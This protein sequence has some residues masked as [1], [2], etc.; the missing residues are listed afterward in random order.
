MI[1][2]TSVIVNF[3]SLSVNANGF[4]NFYS[5]IEFAILSRAGG[6]TSTD[7]RTDKRDED[8]NLFSQFYKRT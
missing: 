6:Q 2:S 3:N 4:V 1:T 8:N 5:V 7:G